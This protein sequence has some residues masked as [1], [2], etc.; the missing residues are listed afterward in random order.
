MVITISRTYG[1]GGRVMG[2]ALAKK[3]GCKFRKRGSRFPVLLCIIF[4]KRH[5]VTF[6]KNTVKIT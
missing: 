3:L 1:S 2:K 5:P 6:I 4:K